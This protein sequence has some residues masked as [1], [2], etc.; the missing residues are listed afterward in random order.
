MDGLKGLGVVLAGAPAPQQ[1][2]LKQIERVDIGQA[3]AD[4]QNQREGTQ[5]QEQ[6]EAQTDKADNQTDGGPLFQPCRRLIA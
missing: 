1:V 2:E 3:Q 6:Y 4:R 5:A